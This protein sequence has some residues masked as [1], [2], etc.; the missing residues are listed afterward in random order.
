MQHPTR[1]PYVDT[2]K[3]VG[4]LC[5]SLLGACKVVV[6]PLSAL[7]WPCL[8]SSTFHLIRLFVSPNLDSVTILSVRQLRFRFVVV[9]CS[10][11]R[12]FQGNV[13]S[14]DTN[15]DAESCSFISFIASVSK[16]TSL[17]VVLARYEIL[18]ICPQWLAHK[19]SIGRCVE[20]KSYR[21]IFKHRK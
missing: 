16:S 18:R 10:S 3:S 6:P 12:V 21:F 5:V 15:R 7:C 9:A 20:G 2:C 17:M 4:C 19:H 1:R 13:S 8:R 11:Y 14:L